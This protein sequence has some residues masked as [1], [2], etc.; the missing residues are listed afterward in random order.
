MKKKTCVTIPLL[1]LIMN[2]VVSSCANKSNERK[3]CV[4]V[5]VLAIN[6]FHGSFLKNEAQGVPGVANLYLCLDSLKKKYPNNITVSLGDNF[7]GS[8]FSSQTKDQYYPWLFDLLDIHISTVGNHEFDNKVSFLADKWK[9]FLPEG[10]S[11]ALTYLGA[12]ISE[13]SVKTIVPPYISPMMNVVIPIKNS[14]QKVTLSLVGLLTSTC[15]QQTRA[16]NV[17]G[18]EFFPHYYK[19]LKELSEDSIY[20]PK[21]KASEIQLLLLHLGTDMKNGLPVWSSKLDAENMFGVKDLGYDGMFTSHSHKLVCGE[22]DGIPVTQALKYG[23]YVAIQSFLVDTITRMVY[24]ETPMIHKVAFSNVNNQQTKAI[25]DKL[26]KIMAQ[27]KNNMG[28]SLSEKIAFC[29]E[30]MTHSRSDKDKLIPLGSLICESFADRVRNVLKL[31]DDQVVIGLSHFG[32][33]RMN[34]NKGEVKAIDAGQILPFQNP[35]K[36]YKM[37]GQKLLELIE[38]GLNNKEYGCL[39]MNRL[40]LIVKDQQGKRLLQKAIYNLP[41]GEQ[42]EI[43]PDNNYY[44]VID[45]FIAKGGDGY[46]CDNYSD[47][48][49]EADLCSTTR[50]FLNYLIKIKKV[51]SH[52][53]VTS[54]MVVVK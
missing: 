15:R 22:L 35:L 8:Y 37:E 10:D 33:I 19:I 24:P 26:N 44:V 12:N 54:K 32:S 3:N 11:L 1:L 51:S 16:E 31:S 25:N 50:A 20:G 14:S 46:I 39:Q 30:T 49:V 48:I 38:Y 13:D 6:D 52:P 21:L 34:L 42:V 29:E 36:L 4:E 43:K 40:K 18:L 7:G 28:L 5:A 9:S 45:Q 17:Q 23:K 2:F 53:D 41:S 47:I 27:T